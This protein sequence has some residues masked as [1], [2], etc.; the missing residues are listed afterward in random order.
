MDFGGAIDRVAIVLAGGG[1]RWALAGGVALAAY[2]HARLTLDVDIV[3]ERPAQPALIAALE[4][5]GYRTLYASSGFSNHRHDDPG[6]GRIDLIYVDA[7]TAETL[8]ADTREL[9]GP[10]GRMITV[11]RPEH[12]IAMKVQAIKN[13]P[14]RTWQDMADIGFLLAL[15][16]IDRDEARRH[17]ERAGLLERWHDLER[18][19]S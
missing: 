17:F 9:P 15:P 6:R 4:A 14:E 8:F 16:G 19:S 10:N 13:A 5:D 2:G 1:W 18:T 12:L 3:T 11:P 7:G